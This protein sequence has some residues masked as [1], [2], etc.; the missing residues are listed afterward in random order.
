MQK[1][2][3]VWRITNHFGKAEFFFFVISNF[4]LRNPPGLDIRLIRERGPSNFQLSS[5]KDLTSLLSAAIRSVFSAATEEQ[6][7]YEQ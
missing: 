2:Q 1:M 4:L 7:F 6:D 3:A 5:S